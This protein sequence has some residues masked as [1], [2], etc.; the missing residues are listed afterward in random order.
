MKT[1]VLTLTLL[2]CTVS[3]AY[4][5]HTGSDYVAFRRQALQGHAQFRKQAY[6]GYAD[7]LKQV[8]HE[9][10]AFKGQA[11]LTT[12]KPPVVPQAAPLT[13]E[14]QPIQ[15]PQPEIPDKKPEPQA[16]PT[17][18]VAPVT[19]LDPRIDNQPKFEFA[20]Y[21]VTMQC[22]KMAIRPVP[23]LQPE[24][25]ARAWRF[26]G[27]AADAACAANSLT[28]LAQVYGFNDWLTIELARSYVDALCP[29]RSATDRIVLQHY[30]LTQMGYEVRMARTD[31]QLVLL[32]PTKQ[33]MYEQPY[34]T[35]G[36][37]R[38]YVFA[39]RVSPVSE[40]TR[41]Y[42]SYDLP[43]G[44]QTGRIVS[45]LYPAHNGSSVFGQ[46]VPHTLTDGRLTITVHVSKNMMEALRHYPPMD[47]PYY[48]QSVVSPILHN[49][50]WRQLRAQLQ[51]M[52]QRDAVAA[53][54][55]FG[56]Y[57]FAYATD[58]EQ[59]GYEKAYFLEE[60]FYYPKNDCEDRAIFL[61]SAIRNVLGLD[62]QLVQ[63]PGHECTAVHFTDPSVVGD[64]YTYEGRS[65]LICDPCYIGA[66]IGRC[67]P[68]YR[69]MQPKV[70][71]W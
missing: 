28:Q 55:H 44:A 45:L 57:A 31:R 40:S 68:D 24:D 23:S 37:Q 62:V 69:Q 7:F 18:P 61:A 14:P 63:F 1:K 20:F 48:A 43:S 51:G 5:Q 58:G 15:L 66:G 52:S 53:L 32:V 38:Y 17:P 50:V 65:Y 46:Q 30:L 42:Y 12:P 6:E 39:D 25:I 3:V 60:N 9:F 34:L 10:E 41:R 27:E 35:I 71:L 22:H 36:N 8:W 29:Q 49:D 67:M 59:H 4:S 16:R 47:I 26:Y 11:R 70:Q 21:N 2:L 13:V 33:T 56:Q 54:L 19:S 64:G